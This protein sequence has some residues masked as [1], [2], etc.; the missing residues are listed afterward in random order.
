MIEILLDSPI[1]RAKI[2]ER[3]T[4]IT[5][6]QMEQDVMTIIETVKN[7]G[8]KAINAYTKR[9]DHVTVSKL[10]VEQEE[11]KRAYDQ[12][13]PK[14]IKSLKQAYD[15]IFRFHEKQQEN[16]F[17]DTSQQGIMVGVKITAIDAVGLYI[18][19]GT[20]AYPSTILMNVIP[21]II[22]GCTRIALVCPPTDNG[23]INKTVLATAYLC[24]ITE[25]YRVGGA[26]AIAALT[27]GSQT[28]APV[29]KIC[30][31]GNAYVATAKKLVSGIVGID[32]IAGPSEVL[33]I[34]DNQASPKFV[35]SDMIAQAEHDSQA[36]T[37][38][39]TLSEQFAKEVNMALK[40]QLSTRQRKE[41]IEA[42]LT[43]NGYIVLVENL[44][45]AT[46]I[47]N[48]IAPEHLELAVA[49]PFAL[50]SAIKHAGSIFLGNYT[51]E[52]LGDYFAGPNHTLPTNGTSRFTSGLCVAD[53]TKKSSILYYAKAALQ[54]AKAAVEV[55]AEAE[56]LDGHAYAMSIRFEEEN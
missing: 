4:F 44:E 6:K 21:A 40:Q 45:A 55:I 53:F 29:D 35:A 36:T 39:L 5:D 42:A 26:Q 18:P 48:L 11:L 22:A 46:T 31:P 32:M 20:A 7:Q 33:I 14:L 16:G 54:Q 8:D 49:D 34:A 27:Y 2:I 52:V 3:P 51:P 37:I 13:D 41:I 23:E 15:N 56:G 17:M 24:G 9:F 38:L 1:A 47:S 30:G 28:I 50:L 25:V 43:N 19:G 10:K 12:C